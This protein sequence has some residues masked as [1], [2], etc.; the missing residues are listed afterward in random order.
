MFHPA[1]CSALRLELFRFLG[2]T[3]GIAIRSKITLDLP[4]PSFIWKCVVR[5]P[6]DERDIGK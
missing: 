5:E 4:L 6:L 3:V 1:A 2:Q